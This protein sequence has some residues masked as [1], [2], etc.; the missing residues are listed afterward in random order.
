MKATARQGR[1]DTVRVHLEV[2]ITPDARTML[3]ELARSRGSSLSAMVESLV[4]EAREVDGTFDVDCALG[5]QAWSHR[6]SSLAS[7]VHVA[8]VVHSQG[9]RVTAIRR[10]RK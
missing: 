8:K 4:R 3:G 9:G 10:G 6:T 1:P 7:A 5:K 2:S